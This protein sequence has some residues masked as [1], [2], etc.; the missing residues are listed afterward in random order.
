[1]PRLCVARCRTHEEMHAFKCVRRLSGTEEVAV[2]STRAPEPMLL[3]PHNVC[4]QLPQPLINSAAHN[5]DALVDSALSC[6]VHRVCTHPHRS[7]SPSK[8]PRVE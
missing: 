6:M 7:E 8:R 2:A 3:I 5:F 1:M 4:E